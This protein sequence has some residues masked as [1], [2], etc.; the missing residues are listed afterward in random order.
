MII[1][2]CEFLEPLSYEKENNKKKAIVWAK[3]IVN[4]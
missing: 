3:K 4:E 1:G 2:E